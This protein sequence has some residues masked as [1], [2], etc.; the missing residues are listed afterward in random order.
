MAYTLSSHCGRREIEAEHTRERGARAAISVLR[1][2][3]PPLTVRRPTRLCEAN[4]EALT[5]CTGCSRHVR[6][7]ES[8][9]PF[10]GTLLAA[11]EARAA[12]PRRAGRLTRA[13]IFA[14]AA[15]IAPACG[16]TT[17]GETHDT[18][19][20]PPLDE[21]GDE[22]AA[23]RATREEEQRR[24]EREVQQDDDEHIQARPYGAPP[25]RDDFV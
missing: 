5:P 23:R 20:P 8:A 10:C 16:G 13:A 22:E 2:R 3:R 9:C 18:V 17:A 19:T 11:Q 25:R 14:G 1:G 6:S 21:S 15:M 12:S 4:M 24:N 7:T